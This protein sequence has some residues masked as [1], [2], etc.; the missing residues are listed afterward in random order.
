VSSLK[1]LGAACPN[2]ELHKD[3]Q[4]KQNQNQAKREILENIESQ[5]VRKMRPE[6]EILK[7]GEY[8]ENR[9]MWGQ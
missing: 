5:E 8:A 7:N 4:T 9:K 3:L 1:C 6:R 2:P